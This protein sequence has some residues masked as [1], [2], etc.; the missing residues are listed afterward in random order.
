VSPCTAVEELGAPPRD[1]G[2][3]EP[4]AIT[5]TSPSRLRVCVLPAPAC[6]CASSG[7]SYPYCYRCW[8]S[9]A[10]PP[11]VA[12]PRPDGGSVRPG[13]ILAPRTPR[14]A[15]V[16]SAPTPWSETAG[17]APPSV[18]PR[19]E[20]PERTVGSTSTAPFMPSHSK[21]LDDHLARG[22]PQLRHDP[23]Q[24]DGV[25]QSYRR[26]QQR[27]PAGAALLLLVGAGPELP[28]SV[29]EERNWARQHDAGVG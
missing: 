8:S 16:G 10:D 3:A 19:F 26:R 14:S 22:R 1:A 25:L 15:L 20:G 18:F 2:R 11:E 24:V 4:C 9:P 28:E 29:E 23:L 7:G 13:V 21:V 5:L 12:S 17:P 6:G 27:E